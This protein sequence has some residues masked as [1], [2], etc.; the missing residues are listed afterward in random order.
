MRPPTV[1]HRW[2]RGGEWCTR[3][4]VVGM[5]PVFP[6]TFEAVLFWVPLVVVVAVSGLWIARNR[7]PRGKRLHD[8]VPLIFLALATATVI[9]YAHLGELPHWV[10][11]PGVI[12][13]VAGSGFVTWCYSFLG[14]NLSP[15][16]EVV[17]DH[18]VVDRGP[19]RYVRHPGYVGAV[20][21]LVGL[22]LALQSWLALL[23]LLVVGIA[24]LALRIHLEEK[25]MTAELGEPYVS[26]M[27]RTKRFI[28]FV[29]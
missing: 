26:Y 4:W 25:L 6:S 18:Q 20:V 27:A 9:G 24:A 1:D 3:G 19:Y 16:P 5:R 2:G 10:F 29:W 23:V 21:A 15:Y 28:P 8:A 13:F 22:G 11:Y 17:A 12:L 14:T 7:H